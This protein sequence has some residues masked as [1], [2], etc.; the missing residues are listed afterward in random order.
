MTPDQITFDPFTL[1]AVIV[2]T[3]F[4]YWRLKT[5]SATNQ[6]IDAALTDIKA[7]LDAER[8]AN[9]KFRADVL[10]ALAGLQATTLTADQ[11]AIVDGLKAAIVQDTADTTA[12]D[13]ALNPNAPT[14]PA[15]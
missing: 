9:V 3:V 13:A 10:T 1:T 6:T 5:M 4:L 11:Q 12:A 15:A 7:D 8:T 14:A 2:A